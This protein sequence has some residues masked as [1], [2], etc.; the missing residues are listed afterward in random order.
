MSFAPR[1]KRLSAIRF[2]SFADSLFY[3][4][5]RNT[6]EQNPGIVHNFHSA[7]ISFGK[8]ASRQLQEELSERYD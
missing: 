2:F 4:P 8:T 6:V 3:K 7:Q 1:D 5:A